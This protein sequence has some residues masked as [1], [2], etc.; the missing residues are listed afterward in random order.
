M[1]HPHRAPICFACIPYEG[2]CVLVE[3]R[4]EMSALTALCASA[5]GCASGIE[6]MSNPREAD[7]M[8]A[9]ERVGAARLKLDGRYE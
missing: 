6:K 7:L 9:E 2:V 5:A 4:N 8:G 3:E 1:L